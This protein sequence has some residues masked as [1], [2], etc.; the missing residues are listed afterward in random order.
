MRLMGLTRNLEEVDRLATCIE[1]VDRLRSILGLNQKDFLERIGKSKGAYSNWLHGDAY[2]DVIKIAERWHVSDD[3]LRARPGTLDL[4][5]APD[6][7]EAREVLTAHLSQMDTTALTPTKRICLINKLI[8]ASPEDGG[9][10]LIPTLE[11]APWAEWLHWTE[12][13]WYAAVGGFIPAGHRQIEQTALFVGWFAGAASWS[14]WIRTGFPEPLREAD[15]RTKERYLMAAERS[16]FSTADLKE[17][18]RSRLAVK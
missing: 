4:E 15:N 1:R 12:S 8:T 5:P 11:V 16:G 13:D 6:L 3:S 7:R 14:Q 9:L 18:M 10:G 17:F 2:P